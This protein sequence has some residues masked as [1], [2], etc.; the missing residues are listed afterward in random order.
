MIRVDS[1]ECLSF[2]LNSSTWER[3]PDPEPEWQPGEVVD[4]AF[5]NRYC[6]MPDGW[7]GH[8]S[9]NFGETYEWMRLDRSAGWGVKDA[10]LNRP[11]TRLVP[12]VKP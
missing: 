9:A 2:N 4:D 11:L 7:A 6:R 1:D 3:L 8:P 5:G 12:E 10:A